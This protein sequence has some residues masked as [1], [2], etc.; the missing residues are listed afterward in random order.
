MED[1]RKLVPREP[2]EGL[3]EWAAERCPELDRDGLLMET[4][5]ARDWSLETVLDEWARDRKVR[6]VRVQCS[7]CT[8]SALLW[9]AR[10]G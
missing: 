2:P 10:D 1:V 4:V 9:R 8:E 3:L 7:A 5:W 6:A